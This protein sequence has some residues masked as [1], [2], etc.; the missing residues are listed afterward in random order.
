MIEV[1]RQAAPSWITPE[2][3]EQTLRVWQPRSRARLTT[4]DAIQIILS[5]SSL[6]HTLS[7]R[8]PDASLCG[9]G[10]CQQS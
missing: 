3:I 7:G 8:Q 9:P 4:D 6:A 5:V 2:L 1:E 10:S